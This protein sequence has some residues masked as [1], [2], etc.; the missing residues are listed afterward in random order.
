MLADGA[1]QMTTAVEE[2]LRLRFEDFTRTVVLPQ[3]DFA[4]FL[5]ATKAERQGLLRNLLGLDVYTVVRELA[6]TREAVASERADAGERAI[7]AL[8]LADDETAAGRQRPTSRSPRGSGR[9]DRRRVKRLDDLDAA[10]RVP[11]TRRP[12]ARRC[13]RAGWPRSPFRR[14]SSRTSH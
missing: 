2:L 9:L 14:R 13:S 3:G 11:L 1:D 12:A 7:A 10:W 4:R 8:E 5:T 6:K